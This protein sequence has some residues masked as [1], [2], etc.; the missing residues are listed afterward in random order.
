MYA[1]WKGRPSLDRLAW[2]TVSL[3]LDR[4]TK[5]KR[6]R[7]E[8]NVILAGSLIAKFNVSPCVIGAPCGGGLVVVNGVPAQN[9]QAHF[10]YSFENEAN[11]INSSIG[12]NINNQKERK[13]KWIAAGKSSISCSLLCHFFVLFSRLPASWVAPKK[14]FPLPLLDRRGSSSERLGEKRKRRGSGQSLIFTPTP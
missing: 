13:I 10:I 7:R 5:S 12:E 2:L 9:W 6:R 1:R 14:L 11:W 3:D 8:V 4:L